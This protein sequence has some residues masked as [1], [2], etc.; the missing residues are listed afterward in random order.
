MLLDLLQLLTRTKLKKIWSILP[1]FINQYGDLTNN[2][3]NT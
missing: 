3:K 2:T 1:A